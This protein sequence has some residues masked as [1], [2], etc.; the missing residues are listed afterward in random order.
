MK[1]KTP[2]NQKQAI[3]ERV[4]EVKETTALSG[5]K[6]GKEIGLQPGSATKLLNGVTSLSSPL[7]NSIELKFGYRAEW[8]LTGELP[9]KSPAQG[10]LS[11]ENRALVELSGLDGL[12]EA[13][14]RVVL[15]RRRNQHNIIAEGIKLIVSCWEDID[16]EELL[17]EQEILKKVNKRERRKRKECIKRLEE[18]I[19]RASDVK[20]D[21]TGNE[22]SDKD[23]IAFE[24]VIN[25]ALYFGDEWESI[26]HRSEDYER[27]QTLFKQKPFPHLKTQ[28]EETLKQFRTLESEF[29]QLYVLSKKEQAALD[30]LRPKMEKLY[31]T[32]VIDGVLQSRPRQEAEEEYQS[33]LQKNRAR[34]QGRQKPTAEKE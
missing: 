14:G 12:A 23:F 9:K 7:A 26:N 5:R 10:S 8:L 25:Q 22:L 27:L 33:L 4:L 29:D 11:T 17:E 15:C 28:F 31:I 18:Q 19:G 2:D 6:F 30:A 1:L 13:L 34:L 20:F 21:L 16:S 32:T 3:L 24:S